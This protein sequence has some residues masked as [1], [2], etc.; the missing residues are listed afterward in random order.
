LRNVTSKLP[1]RHH[2]EIKARW[3]K[4]FDEARSPAE[5]SRRVSDLLCVGSGWFVCVSRV[6][7]LRSES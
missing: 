2:Q 7:G 6:V 1:E 5:A 4:A 3:W